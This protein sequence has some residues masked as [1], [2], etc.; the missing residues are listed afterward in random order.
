M[1]FSSDC[2]LTCFDYETRC[3]C[4]HTCHSFNV[5]C[6][7]RN[8]RFQSTTFLYIC[9]FFAIKR[10]FTTERCLKCSGVPFASFVNRSVVILCILNVGCHVMYRLTEALHPTRFHSPSSCPNTLIHLQ[11]LVRNG[12]ALI[13]LDRK[14][15]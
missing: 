5:I 10:F 1:S 13:L 6:V 8:V 11:I 4:L 7:I 3:T 14:L 15:I 12:C 2:R 9:I